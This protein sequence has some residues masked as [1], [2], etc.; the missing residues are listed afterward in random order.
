MSQ[1][2]LDH[3]NA[4]QRRARVLVGRKVHT[5]RQLARR[6]HLAGTRDVNVGVV[7]ILRIDEQA[8]GVRSAA[9]LHVADA[10]RIT[11]VADVEDAD[12][13]QPVPADGVLYSL[14]SAVESRTEVLAGDEQ[15]IPV[16]RDVALRCRTHVR[17]FEHGLT[18]IRDVPDLV[19]AEAPLN[20]VVAGE[21]KIGVDPG[22]EL[23]GGPRLRQHPQIPDCLGGVVRSGTESDTRIRSRWRKRHIHRRSRRSL[24]LE[25]RSGERRGENHHGQRRRK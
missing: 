25:S 24:R 7:G 17:R 19:A 13:A 3:F 2:H 16:H 18:G 9:G 5:A 4:E 15:Q 23:L 20:R 1:W 22:G 12:P 21:G 11:D 6:S 8:V 10:L 14:R